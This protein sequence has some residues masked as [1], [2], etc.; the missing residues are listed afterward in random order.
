MTQ[1][2]QQQQQQQEQV[3]EN[4]KRIASTRETLARVETRLE[5]LQKERACCQTDVQEQLN[6]IRQKLYDLEVNQQKHDDSLRTLTKIGG[7]IG[8]TAIIIIP[9]LLELIKT[10]TN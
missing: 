9:L 5:M 6:I 1:Q 8:S 3:T 10:L 7:A 4:S 2:Q